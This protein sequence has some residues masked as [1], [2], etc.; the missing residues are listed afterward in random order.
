MPLGGLLTAAG[1]PIIGG[2]L[3]SIFGSGDRDKQEQLQQQALQAIMGVNTPD[4][5]QMK[6]ALQQYGLAGSLNPN[7]EQTMSQGDSGMSKISTDPRLMQAQMQ[8]LAKLQQMGNGGL[9]PED[10]AALAKIMSQNNSAEHGKE[11][12]IL[13]DMQQRGQGGSG[14]ELAAKLSGAQASA[15]NASQQGLDLAGQASQRA[16]QAISQ[17]GN[18]GGSIQG[19]QFGQQA[20][21]ASAQ[22]AINRFNAQNAQNVA[23][24]NTSATNNA[25]A[26][27]L[28]A[29]Q[30]MMNQNTNLSNQQQ[31]YNKQ[32][33]QQDYENQL[34]K[35]QGVYSADQNAAN[36]AGQRAGQTQSTWAGIGSGIGS[37]AAGI[38]QYNQNQDY[39]NKLFPPTTPVASYAQAPGTAAGYGT[40]TQKSNPNAA[41]GDY[42]SL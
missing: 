6:L 38:S 23:G 7:M 28:A 12:S 33:L 39:M 10:Q 5:N 30:N 13:Q 31:M 8:S 24:T 29:K 35:A 32:L 15:Q 36:Q 37:G 19:Q 22:D 11:Q 40:N 18:L 9:Q 3:G 4:I 16:L 34:R 20:Q 1:A 27:N 2:A 14:A 17:A 41:N 42:T 26:A 25:Q 21:V